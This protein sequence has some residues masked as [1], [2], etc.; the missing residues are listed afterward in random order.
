MSARWWED[1]PQASPLDAALAA[2]GATGTLAELA[3]SIYAQESGS[4]KNTSTSNAG[5]RGGMQLLPSTFKEVADKGMNIDDPVDNARAGLRYLEKMLA[6]AD[7]DPM[8]AAVGYYGGPGGQDKARKAEAVRDPRNPGAPDTL[9][10]GHQVVARMGDGK[11]AEGKSDAGSQWWERYPKASSDSKP[12]APSAQQKTQSVSAGLPKDAQDQP[13]LVDRLTRQAGLGARAVVNGLTTIPALLSDAVAAPINAGLDLVR[14]PGNGFRFQKAQDAIGGAMDALGLPSPQNAAER[15]SGEVVGGLAGG[16]GFVKAGQVLARSGGELAKGVGQVLSAGPGAQ[17]IGGGAGAGA[18]GAVREGGGDA[19]AQV[20]AGVLGALAPAALPAAGGAAVRGVLRGGEAGRQAAAER[21]AAFDAVGAEPTLA[22]VTGGRGARAVEAAA[23]R[24]PGGYGIM[25]EFAQKQ[26]DSMG[27]AIKQLGDELAPGASAIT[28]GEAIQ[29]GVDAFKRGMKTVESGLYRKLDG[30]IP[31]N[32]PIAIDNTTV[33]LAKLN[34]DIPGAPNL[35]EL[36]KNARIGGIERAALEDLD[37]AAKA[38]G[39]GL[40]YQAIKKLRTLVGNE[41]ASNSLVADV[42][43]S[44]WMPLYAALSDDLGVAAQNAGP[45]AA[46]AWRWANAFTKTQTARLEELNGIVT[47]DTPEAVFRA[48]T[49]GTQE[50]STIAKRV[51]SV[52]PQAERREVAA[53]L[54]QRMGRAAPGQQGA[55]GDAFSS[56]AFLSNL[57]RMSP[58]ARQ[59]L[60]GRTDVEGVLTRI[61]DFATLAEARRQGG[62]M[63][64]GN[65][66]NMSRAAQF[67]LA[68]GLAGGLVSAAAGRPGPLLAVAAVPAAAN[69]AAR[70]ATSPALREMAATRTVVNPGADAAAAGAL[71]RVGTEDM[72]P[73]AP[74]SQQAG[75]GAWWSQMPVADQGAALQGVGQGAAP[76]V[77]AVPALDPMTLDVLP[78]EMPEVI[79]MDTR[80][81]LERIS[82]AKTVDEAIAAAQDHAEPAKMEMTAAQK[83]RAHLMAAREVILKKRQAL[84][85]ENARLN[86]ERETARVHRVAAEREKL[87]RM[88]ERAHAARGGASLLD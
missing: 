51:V 60:F 74:A 86:T 10:Y 87:A 56:E 9:Q 8:L 82:G 2:E 83:E 6:R 79:P 68:G 43:R 54:L 59:T 39:A 12:D 44:K 42:P 46:E 30:F 13:G 63:F 41:L 53:A 57:S 88:R 23:A 7:G 73:P 26:L 28:A 27:A 84:A 65:I 64:D 78:H 62:K 15:V 76:T 66:D 55:A 35:S 33:A 1:M 85:G 70:A 19:P 17:I 24:T 36:F 11:Q 75:G 58:E 47:R 18:A 40:P 72:A 34:A 61:D 29:R 31:A 45:G 48:A 14:G 49:S 38:G 21:L 22:Q 5:A 50:G 32:T 16:A 71:A 25:S 37:A 20:A 67:G 80:G 69:L 52:L 77:S 3:R 4:G 81:T